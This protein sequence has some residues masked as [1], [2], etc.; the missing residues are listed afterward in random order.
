MYKWK[1]LKKSAS[2]CVNYVKWSVSRHKRLAK[3][4]NRFSYGPN[5]NNHPGT[6]QVTQRGGNSQ[7]KIAQTVIMFYI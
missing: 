6:I 5:S 4:Q 2:I 3:L 1:D 7:N